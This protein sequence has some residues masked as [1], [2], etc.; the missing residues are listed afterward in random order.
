MARRERKSDDIYNAR[1]RYYRAAQRHLDRAGKLSGTSAARERQL[2]RA[3]FERALETYDP[4][5]RQKISKPMR[6]IASELGVD[7]QKERPKL[8]K[9][10]DIS[11]ARERYLE[12]VGKLER[13]SLKSLEGEMSDAEK[14]REREAEIIFKNQNISHRILGGLVD[15]WRGKASK[16]DSK[17]G[18]MKVDK[19]R[20]LPILFE[21]YGVSKLSDLLAKIEKEVGETLYQ[22]GQDEIYEVIK[23]TLQKGNANMV[24]V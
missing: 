3:E 13:E 7:I 1:R 4:A 20:I 5:Q 19:K 8:E 21:H 9:G 23:L 16:F 15:I 24:L 18:K 6:R 10:E 22:I 11:K 17:Q 14:R 12:K 2:A